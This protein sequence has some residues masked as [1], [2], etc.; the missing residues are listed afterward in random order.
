MQQSDWLTDIQYVLSQQNQEITRKFL[1][2][3]G[4]VWVRRIYAL[5]IPQSAQDSHV[6]W[7]PRRTP[8]NMKVVSKFRFFL[9]VVILTIGGMVLITKNTLS[10][11]NGTTRIVTA[12]LCGVDPPSFSNVHLPSNKIYRDCTIKHRLPWIKELYQLLVHTNNSRSPQVNFV[13]ADKKAI[14]LL[15]NWLIMA[16]VR[17]TEPLQNVVVLGLDVQVCDLLHPR[18]ISC[19][20]IDPDTI[21]LPSAQTQSFF[22]RRYLAPQ[23]RLL[24]IRLVNYWGFSLATYDTDALIM[25]NPQALY[26]AHKE[27]TV[28]AGAANVGPSLAVEKWGFALCPGAMLIR[29]GPAAGW[30]ISTLYTMHAVVCLRSCTLFYRHTNTKPKRW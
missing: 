25:K 20:Y 16:L 26:D 17:L 12:P 4:G 22:S 10:E 29:S 13:V 15:I 7:T 5:A 11:S 28:I 19:I 23:I 9:C 18:N 3:E 2:R 21:I 24:V 14:E 1:S 30:F 8:S 27:V 6:K